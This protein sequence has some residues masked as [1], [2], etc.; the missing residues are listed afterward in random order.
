MGVGVC[1]RLA[2]SWL[3]MAAD[4]P[5]GGVIGWTPELEL[6]GL[7]NVHAEDRRGRWR[8]AD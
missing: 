1:L 7:T 8:W 6:S 2:S 3:H 5:G 4:A